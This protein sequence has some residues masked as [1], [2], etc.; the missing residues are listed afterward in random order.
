MMC[1]QIHLAVSGI[2]EISAVYFA[3]LQCG[4]TYCFMDRSAEHNQTL[5]SFVGSP[6]D[7]HFFSATHQDTC[8]VYPW[9]PRAAI[10]ET[11]SFYLQPDLLSFREYDAFHEHIMSAGNISDLERGHS[12]WDWIENFPTA[13]SAVCSSN[14]FH[15]YMKWENQWIIDQNAKYKD[16]LHLIRNCLTACMNKYVSPVQDIR[17]VVNPIKC[18]YSADYHLRENC[19]IACCGTLRAD[20]IIH[21]F[22]HHVIHPVV[23]A[24]RDRFLTGNA[25]YPGIDQSYYLSG[26]TTG[27]LNAFEEYAVRETTK[28]IMKMHFPDDLGTYLFRLL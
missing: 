7:E 27:R 23:M 19:F 11:A 5:Q 18:V 3:L 13:L 22:L 21:E 1:K 17:I 15:C 4:Y 24:E 2:P 25:A 26:D 10:L 14:A 6:V 9:W 8:E 12:L 28:E 20:S 16:E